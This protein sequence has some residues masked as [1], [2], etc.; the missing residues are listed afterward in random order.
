LTPG[1]EYSFYVVAT[2]FNG[3]GVRSDII[4]L[5]SCIAPFGVHPPHLLATTIDSVKLRWSHPES[6]GGCPISS[7]SILTDLGDLGPIATEL[8]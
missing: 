1:V 6:D 3:E 8:D 7:F 5:K 2:N 4:R